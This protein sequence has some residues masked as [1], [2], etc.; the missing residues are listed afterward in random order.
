SAEDLSAWV[1]RRE[2]GE[3]T[4]AEPQAEPADVAED[5][6]EEEDELAA[7][8]AQIRSLGNK[9]SELG[10]D[11]RAVARAISDD[12]VLDELVNMD[13]DELSAWAEEQKAPAKPSNE[14]VSEM[15]RE[16]EEMLAE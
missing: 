8:P 11:S 1:E 2:T 16:Q 10:V 9:L 14:E 6:E 13:M 4:P 3:I 7:T 12:S 15:L 5:V